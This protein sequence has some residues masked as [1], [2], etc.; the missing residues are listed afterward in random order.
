LVI[1]AALLAQ[2]AEAQTAHLHAAISAH[3][4]VPQSRAFSMQNNPQV[5]I[6]EVNVGV[7]ILEQVATTTMD[8]SL[9]NPSNRRLEAE[10]LVP[11]PDGAVVRSFTFQGA[12]SEAQAK[13][14]P[15]DEARRIYEAIVA[16]TKDPAL[17]EFVG[18]NLIRSAVFPVEARGTQ[19]VRLTYEHILPADGQRV[20]YVLPRSESLG[21]N[22][23][24]KI[25]VRIKSAQ[26]IATVYSP[27]HP[28]TTAKGSDQIVSVQ[29]TGADLAPGPFRL[30][31]LLEKGGV[32]ASLISYP[33]PKVGGGY[34]LLLAGLPA[35]PEQYGKRI[36]REVTLVMDRSGSM[37]GEKMEQAR[38]AALQIIAG[39][40]EGES[41][42]L[43]TYNEAVDTFAPG[44][45]PKTKDTVTKARAYIQGIQAR[46]G[47]NIHDALLESLRPKPAPETL[48][49]VLF[50]TDG[51]PT[52]GQTS[53]VAIRNVAMKA[54]PYHRRVFTFGVGVDVNTPLLEKI[55]TE[56]RA[57]ATFVMPKEDVELKVAG[58]F[59]RLSGPILSDPRLKVI[60]PQGQP[61]IGRVR[62]LLPHALPDLFEGDQLVLLG[63][64][65]GDEPLH[66]NLEGNYL[67]HTKR[68]QF[69][70][71][72]DQAT[73]RNAFVPRLW[74]SRK[75][76]ILVDA[77][78]QSGA[79]VASNLSTNEVQN[80]P[81]LK[82]LVDEIVRISTEF[83]ILTEYTAFLAQEGTDL[84]Q[85]DQVLA[86]AQKNFYSR[87]VNTRHGLG[88][89][90][91]EFNGQMQKGQFCLNPS[92]GYWD[93]NMNRVAVSNVQQVCDRAFYRRGNRWVDSAVVEKATDVKPHQVIEFGS[94][95]YHTL[96]THLTAQ[97]RQGT[98]ALAGE[99]LM[100]VEG[101]TVLIKAPAEPQV[102]HS[103]LLIKK[104]WT[105]T[106]QS[107][108]AGGSDYFVLR[109]TTPGQPAREL[110][111]FTSQQISEDQLNPLVG[112]M[113]AATGVMQAGKPYQPTGPFEQV[114]V[115]PNGELPTRGA[116]LE[117]RSIVEV[118]ETTK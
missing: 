83:G 2:Q 106:P 18:L 36:K 14:L 76:G 85:K 38:E 41:F 96:V 68:F 27:S 103:G 32:T 30:S 118:P 29:A 98:V 52:V 111:L 100:V 59:K 9:T 23:P 57:I 6:Q 74:A 1:G 15:K 21:N 48:P 72:V 99:I 110:I 11:V 113:V 116:G 61:A 53:E 10:M 34:F 4:I 5:Q 12:A 54:N 95:A 84:A 19:K 97:N 55:A 115:T 16:K 108:E 105:K 82:E 69:K 101:K 47:T 49:L 92:N 37:N 66:F 109:I 31:Y 77:I 88:S 107:F 7:V 73:T 86:E 33:D 70:F 89:V 17:L 40:E 87:A 64:Y 112:K 44:P 43:I 93:A 20:D 81:K 102:T 58:V 46:G 24:W 91:Q 79:D 78:R 71:N 63:Q 62:D 90:N 8:I 51:L 28:L 13:L 22:I 35:N 75:I 50:L 39:L 117:V 65:I 56:T 67:G 45:V 104:P 114:P 25:S 80:N 42:N 26:N 60:D 94:P 3:V